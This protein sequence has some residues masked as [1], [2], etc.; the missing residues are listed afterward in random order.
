MAQLLHKDLGL[1]SDVAKELEV[2][3]PVLALVKEI[4]Q[5]AKAER[6]WGRGYECSYK[7]L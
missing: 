2:S 3:T 1:A 7:M 5:I 4:F 6:I